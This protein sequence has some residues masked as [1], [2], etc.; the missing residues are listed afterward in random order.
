MQLKKNIIANYIGQFYV[1]IIGIVMVPFY[2]KYL[3]AEA[4]GLV[5]FFALIQSWMALLDMGIS[6]TLS[7][8]VAK[9]KAIVDAKEKLLFKNLLHSLEFI[10]IFISLVIAIIIFIYSDWISLNWL[11]VQK[12]DLSVVTDCISLMGIITGFRFLT[13]LYRSGINGAEEQVW[14]NIVNIIFVTLKFVGV[15]F[16]LYFISTDV[17]YFFVY[18]LIISILE[19]I[20]LSIKFY[21]VMDIGR[22]KLYFSYF[23]I[24]PILPFA[25]G[26][27][28]TSIIWVFLTQLD[29][30]LLSNILPLAE[31]GYFA[32][33]GAVANAVLQ[34]SAPISKA[35]LP[36]MT[37]LFSQNKI[38]EMIKVYKKSTQLMVVLIFSIVA[39]TAFYSYEL[40]YSWT[41][42]IKA[43]NWA[44]DVLFWYVLGNGIL[45]VAAFQYYLQ[46]VYGKLKLHVLYNT[47]SALLSI[48]LIIWTAYTYGVIG[49]AIVWF[50]FRLISFL[51]WTPYI[52]HRFAPGIHKDWIL[53]DIMPIF[54]STAIYISILK[55]IN[56]NF[57]YSRE[58]IFGILLLIGFILLIINSF[59]SS[60]VR[61]III[62]FIKRR[63][64]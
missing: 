22:F 16:I 7:R 59:V 18:Q 19:F 6:P 46:F 49:V 29:K 40:L 45:T 55:Y 28:Y 54:I 53:K 60:E 10:F 47:V 15:F 1:I 8:E 26:I 62:N 36:R 17:F 34:I 37:S 64:K 21:S 31:Y 57:D 56:I 25:M 14:L 12:L 30:L 38:D 23:A 4:Y 48:P 41:G 20:V 52:H 5:G 13:S 39:I 24:K 3:G 43:S 58:V 2:L 44:K 27:A 9:V 63:K 50:V 42:D 35:I 51:I 61:K 11:N 33:V 32:L